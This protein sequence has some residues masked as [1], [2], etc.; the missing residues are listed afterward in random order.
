LAAAGGDE[1]SEEG[2]RLVCGWLL[3]PFLACQEDDAAFFLGVL[4][5]FPF[6]ISSG[7]KNEN[8]CMS[9]VQI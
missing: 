9:H 8:T 6:A 5:D 2:R 1:G 7:S 4:P 3:L